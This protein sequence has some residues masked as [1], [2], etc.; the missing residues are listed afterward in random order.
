MN[1]E[2]VI[3][4]MIAL[5]RRKKGGKSAAAKQ[6]SAM[7]RMIMPMLSSDQGKRLAEA[8]VNR[9]RHK[10]DAMWEQIRAKID[11]KLEHGMRAH[12]SSFSTDDIEAVLLSAINR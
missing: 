12:A 6:R 5:A 9:D 2:K 4:N 1:N 11:H 8:I 3:G 7:L 10:F